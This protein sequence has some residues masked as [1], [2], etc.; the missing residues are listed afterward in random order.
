MRLTESVSWSSS[1]P[2]KASASNSSISADG[3]DGISR[4]DDGF[5][6]DFDEVLGGDE[7]C[8]DKGVG[9]TDA[10]KA[11]AMDAGDSFPVGDVADK[12][13]G[14]DDIVEGAAKLDDGAFDF[15]ND[16]TRLGGGIAFADEG[17]AI[18]G[19]GAGDMD[20]VTDADSARVARDSFKGGAA[21]DV[22]ASGGIGHGRLGIE[23]KGR[24]TADDG[25]RTTNE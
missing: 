18:G 7:A 25:R 16:E 24:R 10:A 22:S 3:W 13:A 8:L 14:A 23:D 5:S 6:F 19:G 11:F 2:A 15:V 20:V 4:A 17:A 21:A 9:G 1:N 12:D